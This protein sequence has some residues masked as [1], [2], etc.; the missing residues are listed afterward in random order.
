MDNDRYRP[1]DRRVVNGSSLERAASRQAPERQFD[2][3]P[4][5]QPSQVS[6]QQSGNRGD[7]KGKKQASRR[8]SPVAWVLLAV[9]TILVIGGV[10]WYFLNNKETATGINT[11]KYQAVF[12]SNGQ[13]YFG[14]LER[15]ND[16]YF[17]LS[18]VYYL[19]QKGQTTDTT[20]S[21]S[22]TPVEL[23]KLGEKEIH[24]PEDV[25]I[26]SKQQILLYENLNDDS[27][28]VKSVYQHKQQAR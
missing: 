27:Q 21:T 10:A 8:S 16:D 12:L 3:M 17:K 24:G 11:G 5:A 18:D 6:Y 25:M 7:N 13:H 20:T 4:P 26:I 2:D 19:E 28:V 22:K 15:M 1:A 14:K 23:R 9:L